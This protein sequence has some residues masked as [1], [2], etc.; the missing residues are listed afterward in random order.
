MPRRICQQALDRVIAY[1]DASGAEITSE[2]CRQALQL[3]EQ[4][5]SKGDEGGVLERVMDRVPDT[6]EL[7][8]I[9]VP[10][11]R[12]PISRG[13]ICYESHA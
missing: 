8:T 6:F 5:L 9:T 12:P 4:A 2:G 3:V 13:S 7:S 10:A 1:L 11:H